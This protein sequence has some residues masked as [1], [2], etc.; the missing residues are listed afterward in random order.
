MSIFTDARCLRQ[1]MARSS[2]RDLCLLESTSLVNQIRNILLG[3]RSPR[4][5][6]T[7]CRLGIPIVVLLRFDIGPD[8]LGR[9]Q[10]DTV[11]MHTSSFVMNSSRPKKN[12]ASSSRKY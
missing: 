5:G 3:T 7:R 8:V 12:G 11:A 6:R 4:H 2:A 1:R 9:H 10:P